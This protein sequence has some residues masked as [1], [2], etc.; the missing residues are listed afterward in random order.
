MLRS[1]IVA[2]IVEMAAFR[3][4]MLQIAQGIDAALRGKKSAGSAKKIAGANRA[5]IETYETY[6]I[7][8]LFK[9]KTPCCQEIFQGSPSAGFVFNS[10]LWQLKN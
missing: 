9:K 6:H 2:N 3:F 4:N 7:E 1:K 10:R 8:N 5:P